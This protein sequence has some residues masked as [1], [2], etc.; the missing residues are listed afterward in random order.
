MGA[1]LEQFAGQR[2]VAI[3]ARQRERRF[4]ILVR[5]VYV[6]AG[7]DQE[8]GGG[9]VI[10]MRRPRESGGAVGLGRVYGGTVANQGL[11][12]L[13]IAPLYGVEKAE[14]GGG[15]AGYGKEQE[16]NQRTTNRR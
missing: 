5:R 4:A 2:G 3:G 1:G 11:D 10:Q 16:R 15:E 9:L 8:F 6:R 14:I 12:G 7:G 13:S